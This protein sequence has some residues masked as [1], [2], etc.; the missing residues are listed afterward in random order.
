MINPTRYMAV[1]RT[2]IRDLNDAVSAFL[3]E[4]WVLHGGITF[5]IWDDVRRYVQVLVQ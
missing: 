3:E 2:D 1:E 5:Y 4:G